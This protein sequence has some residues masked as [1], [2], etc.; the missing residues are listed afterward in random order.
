[1]L[2]PIRS[3]QIWQ[4]DSTIRAN[5]PNRLFIGAHVTGEDWR[6]W[7]GIDP[8]PNT[9]IW[10]TRTIRRAGPVWAFDL[11]HRLINLL[12]DPP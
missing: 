9:R 7:Y 12:W 11:S 8:D 1:V 5:H 6:T 4:V 3:G 10:T 2:S